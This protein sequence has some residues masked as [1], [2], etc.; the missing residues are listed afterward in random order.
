MT[1]YAVRSQQMTQVQHVG[2][3]Q[4]PSGLYCRIWK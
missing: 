4:N 1:G 3:Q 2:F